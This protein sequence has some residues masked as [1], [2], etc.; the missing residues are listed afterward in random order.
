[1][2]PTA[3]SLWAPLCLNLYCCASG[4]VPRID[5]RPPNP[6]SCTVLIPLQANTTTGAGGRNVNVQLLAAEPSECPSVSVSAFDAAGSG[7]CTDRNAT[8]IVA[9]DESLYDCSSP[10]GTTVWLW[11]HVAANSMVRRWGHG[12]W[13]GGHPRTRV[14]VCVCVFVRL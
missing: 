6:K 8:A 14:C 5:A 12:G 11:V 2:L 3:A 10:A 13:G 7:S 9:I 1:M 4:S